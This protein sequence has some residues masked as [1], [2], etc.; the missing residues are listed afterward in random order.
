MADKELVGDR[1]AVLKKLGRDLR[2]AAISL[3][4]DEARY[5][6]AQYY[7]WQDQ[8]LRASNRLRTMADTGKPHEVLNWLGN[9]AHVIE[10]EIKKALDVYTLGQPIG[11]WARSH[12]GLGPVI[13]AGL[14]ANIDIVKCR[15]VG[16]LWAYAGLDPTKKWKKGEKRPFNPELKV[17]AWKLGAS[18]VWV[19]RYPDAY[20]GHVYKARKKYEQEKNARLEYADQAREKLATTKIGD[21]THAKNWYLK[22]MLPPARI[23]LRA[24]RYAAKLFLAHMWQTWREL[25]GLPVVLPYPIA[26][27]GH[28]HMITPFDPTTDELPDLPFGLQQYE[29]AGE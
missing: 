7:Q 17:L 18:F 9:Q 23:Q 22:G 6:V 2:L 10:E 24:Q 13:T 27:L 19:A 1:A 25:E 29:S 8:R 14:I 28:E 26:K 16:N 12:K 11:K 20:Y 4:Q 15:T 3:D 5:L 21:D